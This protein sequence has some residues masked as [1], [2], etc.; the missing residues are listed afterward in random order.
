ME[1]KPWMLALEHPDWFQATG[2]TV[3]WLLW[4]TAECAISDDRTSTIRRLV[5]YQKARQYFVPAQEAWRASSP[6][7]F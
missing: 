7:P 3:S 5:R 2:N 1:R 6:A 4:R